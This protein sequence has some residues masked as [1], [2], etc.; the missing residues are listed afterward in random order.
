MTH[1][2]VLMTAGSHPPARPPYY[3][4][5]HLLRPVLDARYSHLPR[6][7]AQ[8]WRY[9]VTLVRLQSEGLIH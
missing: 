4:I 9:A 6:H 5:Q 7:H 8:D 1:S 2:A 3:Y